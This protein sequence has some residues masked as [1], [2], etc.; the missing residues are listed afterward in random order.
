MNGIL[1]WLTG[2]TGAAVI[3]DGHS[4]ACIWDAEVALDQTRG[5]DDIKDLVLMHVDFLLEPATPA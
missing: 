2:T 1:A 4:A 5:F 3:H